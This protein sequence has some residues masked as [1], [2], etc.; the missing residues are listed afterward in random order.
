[1]QATI[2]SIEA[3]LVDIPTIR[4]H[5]LS[6]TT[7]GLQTMVIVRVTD[8]DGCQGLGEAT[9]IGGLAYGPESPEGI[10]LTIDH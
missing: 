3:I 7:M 9:T 1:M 10:K 2:Q 6:M 5:R 4:P 8:S